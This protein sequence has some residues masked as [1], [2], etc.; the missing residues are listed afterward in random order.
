MLTA[1]LCAALRAEGL[2]IG[3]WKPVQLARDGQRI[4]RWGT[5]TGLHGTPG[6]P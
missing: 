1:A 6:A 4:N 3:V 2:N 5:T